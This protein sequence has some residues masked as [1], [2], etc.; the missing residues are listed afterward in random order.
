M[1]A[2]NKDIVMFKLQKIMAQVE[3]AIKKQE[4]KEEVKNGDKS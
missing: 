3:T 1:E 4:Q 2:K